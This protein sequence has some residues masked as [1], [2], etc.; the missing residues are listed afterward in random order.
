MLI[1]GGSGSGKTNALFNLKDHQS[2][3]DKIYSYA[4]GLYEAKYQLLTNKQ[5]S[6]WR[7]KAFQWSKAFIEYSSDIDTVDNK[8][9]LW[10]LLH[11]LILL[12]QKILE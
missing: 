11:N 4:K 9:F 2:D 7:I 1:I 3:N 8:T 10:F 5:E 6:K 12:Y